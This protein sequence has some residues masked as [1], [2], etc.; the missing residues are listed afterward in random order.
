MLEYYGLFKTV[1]IVA[2]I[3]WM[4]GLLYLPRL[5]VYHVQASN[6]EMRATFELMEKRLYKFIMLPAMIVTW[7]AGICLIIANPA[8]M[9]GGWLHAKLLL[10]VLLT[11]C[12]HMFG[13]WR[14]KLI[15]GNQNFTAQFFR[16][17][18]EVPTL[19]MIFIVG[20]V[21]MKPF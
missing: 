10:V 2:L 8:L 21:V 7:L 12:H 13:A 14:K 19:L 6:P 11:G 9:S 5:F 20:L 16:I 17:W 1:H 3:S 18:N 4:A 15:H